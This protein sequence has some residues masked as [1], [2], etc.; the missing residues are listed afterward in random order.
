MTANELLLELK[1]QGGVLWSWDVPFLVDGKEVESIVL[2]HKGDDYYFECT[3][4]QF[5]PSEVS[6]KAERTGENAYY[7]QY[8][9]NS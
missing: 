8:S 4:K 1:H 5:P 9:I 2:Q 3:T 7:F 6:I